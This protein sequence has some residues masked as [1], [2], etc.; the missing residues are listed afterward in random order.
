LKRYFLGDKEITE[1]EAKEIEEK[2]REVLRSG[3]IE[4]LL[5]I[6]HIIIRED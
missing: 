6:R 3:T 2:N 5:Q 1:A 4:E